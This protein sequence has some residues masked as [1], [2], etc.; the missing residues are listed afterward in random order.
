MNFFSHKYQFLKFLLPLAILA[1]CRDEDLYSPDGYTINPDAVTFQAVTMRGVRVNTR[2]GEYPEYKPLVLTDE[3]GSHPLYLHTYVTDKIGFRPGEAEDTI[4]TR[5]NQIKTAGDLAQFHT[6][7][8]V[9]AV[10]S[11]GE[12]NYFG[13]KN[14]GVLNGTDNKIWCTDRT[15]Y[16]PSREQLRF[17]AVSPAADFDNL[18]ALSAA[19][20]TVEFDYTAHRGAS[21]ASNDAEAQPDLLLATGV[22]DKKSSISGSAPLEFHHPLSAIKFAVRDVLDGEIVDITLSG[23]LS[24]G[25]CQFT[26]GTENSPVVWT[27]QKTPATFTQAF[28]HPV[29]DKYPADE[30]KDV[31][32]NN[33]MP[34][35]TFMMM[36][37]QIQND[38]EV[39]VRIKR[40]GLTPEEITVKGKILANEITEWLPGHEYIYT[41]SSSAD[42]WMNVLTVRGNE[43]EGYGNIYVYDPENEN[44]P[45]NEN[46]GDFSV[47]SY[48]YRLN[49]QTVT[50]DLPWSA[51]SDG[52]ESYEVQDGNDV[53]RSGKF[54]TAEDWLTEISS[55][56]T[57][58]A[59]FTGSGGTQYNKSHTVQFY[60]HYLVTDWDGDEIMQRTPQFT[61][62]SMSHPY[63][64]STFGGVRGRSTANCYV[65]D[66]GG[67]YCLPLV[68]GNAVING[69]DT[70]STYKCDVSDTHVLS[71]MTDYHGN[72]INSAYID[73]NSAV[74]A[75]L[76]WQDAYN[77]VSEVSL[78][79]IENGGEKM[80]CFYVDPDNIQQGNAIVAV[81]DAQG[82]VIWSWHIW[83]TE[84][85]LDKDGYPHALRPTSTY[86]GADVN[87]RSHLRE[88]GDARVTKNQPNNVEVYMSPYT[89]GW[90]D[91]K[92]V[93]YLKR[94]SMMHFRQ[95]PEKGSSVVLKTAELE[96]IQAG[97]TVRYQIGNGTY[98][99]WGRKDPQVGFVDYQKH[100]K[101][102]FG[103]V[104]FGIK[105][106]TY[107]NIS[108]KD[109]ILH[110]ELMYVGETAGLSTTD[111]LYKHTQDWTTGSK[112]NLWNN[113]PDINI[114]WDKNAA[115]VAGISNWNQVKTIY[116]PCPVG[117]TVPNVGVWRVIGAYG[118]PLGSG[119]NTFYEDKIVK[120]EI[121]GVL[122][123]VPYDGFKD[124]INGRRDYKLTGTTPDGIY[125]YIIYGT[126]E[127]NEPQNHIYLLSN[128]QRW[129]SNSHEFRPGEQDGY[130][131]GVV[132]INAGGNLNLRMF[133]GWSSRWVN[134]TNYCA[135]SCAIGMDKFAGSEE[136]KVYFISDQFIARRAMGR[137]V[138]PVR[139][140]IGSF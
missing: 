100:F 131:A 97:A 129:Y 71:T 39:T 128:G 45:Q 116:D 41:I 8:K 44:F 27:D 75:G 43:A 32:L 125:V 139:D 77:L 25:H 62:Y 54:I 117:Y 83:A 111:E 46:T 73:R 7:F 91:A 78:R 18:I 4:S 106:N 28:N 134:N 122:K 123:D 90:C 110:P 138:R 136:D 65:V 50:E 67:W 37:Q 38:A 53:L 112:W 130:P 63:D 68:Y 86:F 13:W 109:G 114:G 76:I 16:W 22:C 9:L 137:P 1:G 5:A 84:H 42:N 36:P 135:Y 14:A 105:D 30:T 12:E 57:D 115:G 66:R 119:S 101:T 82:D 94:K 87:G 10:K 21:G 121:D 74:S 80:L 127:E 124:Q 99:Q 95:H 140:K 120:E 29:V 48:R 56:E 103:P 126:G 102:N 69:V 85:W 104:K 49:K 70:P 93:L 15:E 47:I 64:L 98:Y 107:T 2:G 79:E 59:P 17:Y 61:G 81:R 92:N 40:T 60:P 19:E 113:S 3:E 132:Q 72:P 58:C 26:P 88:R 23:I 89:L 118:N 35:K 33:L 51:Y 96:L 24:Q 52:S 133:Y 20:G 34:E 31:V 108:L 6:N 11:D 55:D